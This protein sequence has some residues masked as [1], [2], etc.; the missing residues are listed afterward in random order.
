MNKVFNRK[1][2][3]ITFYVLLLLTLA[4]AATTVFA[5]DE[6]T[7]DEVNAIA[8][9]LY[10]PVCE[11]TPLDVCPTEAC[12]QWRE[13]IRLQLSQGMTEAEIK[14]YFVDNYGGRVLAEPPRTGLN[15]L[16]YIIPPVMIVA[17]AFVLFRS[18]REWTKPRAVETGAGGDDE[19]E[20]P[21]LE[22]DDYVTRLEEE[23]KKRK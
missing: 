11:N 2:V 5:Q 16:V 9:Q 21:S 23:L 22:K 13:L 15:W 10:C 18:F 20:G 4:F 1:S 17:G 6:I 19:A 7:D 8:K 3:R 14:Q 12:R